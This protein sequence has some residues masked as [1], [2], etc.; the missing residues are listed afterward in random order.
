MIDEAL[1]LEQLPDELYSVLENDIQD[2]VQI[3]EKTVSDLFSVGFVNNDGTKSL[4]TFDS[5][6]KY[7]DDETGMIR[8]ID[9][10]FIPIAADDNGVAYVNYSNSYSANFPVNISDGVSLSEADFS[11]NMKPANVLENCEPQIVNNELIYDD[12]FNDNTDIRYSLEN[13]GIKESIVVY[14]PTSVENRAMCTVNY[15]KG[16]HRSIRRIDGMNNSPTFPIAENEYRVALRVETS[17]DYDYHYMLQLND[18]SWAHKQGGR[19]P[20]QQLGFINP[21]T[22]VWSGPNSSIAKYDSDVIY[23]AVTR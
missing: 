3:D 16:L 21:S 2:S 7:L 22:Y 6:V 10:A 12:T 11:I 9:N 17:P 13:S 23:F 18:G 4:M 8:F 19:Y 14:E 20:P 1:Q 5:P 15:I